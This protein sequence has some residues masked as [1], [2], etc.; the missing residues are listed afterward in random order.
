MKHKP[1]F[2]TKNVSIAE[3]SI[4]SVF[5]FI[6]SIILPIYALAGIESMDDDEDLTSILSYIWTPPS[7]L[8]APNSPGRQQKMVDFLALL[9]V[10]SNY[11]AIIRQVKSE[12]DNIS[13]HSIYLDCNNTDDAYSAIYN[14]SYNKDYQE[15][16]KK[17]NIVIDDMT[18][19]LQNTTVSEP[20]NDSNINTKKQDQ[21]IRTIVKRCHDKCG[22]SGILKYLV[23]LFQIS[24]LNT[25]NIESNCV[26]SVA[27][28]LKEFMHYI[29][30]LKTTDPLENIILIG[31]VARLTSICSHY[32]IHIDPVYI[33]GYAIE[34]ILDPTKTACTTGTTG[35]TGTTCA[36][37]TVTKILIKTGTIMAILAIGGYI[38]QLLL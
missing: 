37:G 34:N 29:N 27:N 33:H 5:F 26:P 20:T 12:L 28:T 15:H 4:I 36:T 35:T 18:Q 16:T 30:E 1:Y 17:D 31:I 10:H 6:S 11:A 8:V 38:A 7:K 3:I 14:R 9:S 19:A 13:L 32:K 25:E 23:Q 21:C 24:S 2:I 22:N